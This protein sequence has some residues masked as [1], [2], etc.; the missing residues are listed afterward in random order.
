MFLIG[1]DV[2]KIVTLC[3][4]F[5]GYFIAHHK[6][7]HTVPDVF[8]SQWLL[9]LDPGI[10]RDDERVGIIVFWLRRNGVIPTPTC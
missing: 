3:F 2:T 1:Q 7:A 8:V 4:G 9:S 10:R 5:D 6:G